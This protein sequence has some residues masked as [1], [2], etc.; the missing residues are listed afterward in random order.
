MA[1]TTPGLRSVRLYAVSSN[2]DQGTA[3]DLSQSVAP[4]LLQC[5]EDEVMRVQLLSFNSRYTFPQIQLGYNSGFVVRS[6]SV[7]TIV[8]GQNDSYQITVLPGSAQQRTVNVTMPSGDVTDQEI[9]NSFNSTYGTTLGITLTISYSGLGNWQF[10]SSSPFNVNWTILQPNTKAR[11]GFQSAGYS[12]VQSGSTY[13]VQT[14]QDTNPYCVYY[15]VYNIPAGAP[16]LDAVIASLN[17]QLPGITVTDSDGTTAP[18]DALIFNNTSS[19][20]DIYFDFSAARLQVSCAKCLGFV[21]GQSYLLGSSLTSPNSAVIQGPDA[22][23][24][25]L[26]QG[27]SINGLPGSS[28]SN[29][30]QGSKT[31][32]STP[33]V[34]AIIPIDVEYNE[35]IVYNPHSEDPGLYVTDRQVNQLGLSI[36]DPLGY[37]LN[38]SSMIYSI[39]LLFKFERVGS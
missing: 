17:S 9:I 14:S 36:R 8:S 21:R 20:Q 27:G 34:L 18:I 1:T 13:T 22:L 19:K 25:S 30:S 16:N 11:F 28:I 29:F 4:G 7:P 2:A 32:L 39:C 5:R 10:S 15:T 23:I 6:Q 33:N 37:A 12:A 24:L 26:S 3:A 35:K 38:L 31:F